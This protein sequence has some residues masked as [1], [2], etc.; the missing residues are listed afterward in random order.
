MNLNKILI[1]LLLFCPLFSIG[2]KAKAK[3]D[4]KVTGYIQEQD[5]SGVKGAKISLE[6]MARH[7]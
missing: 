7:K 6:K 5:G 1:Y 3:K 2:T 4:F